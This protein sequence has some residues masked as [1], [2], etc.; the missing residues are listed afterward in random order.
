MRKICLLAGASSVH[1][2]R[3]AN[4]FV[5]RGYEVDLITIHK[6]LPGYDP[7]VKLHFLP[8]PTPIGYFLNVPFV[9][10]LLRRIQPDVLNTHY[11]SGYG[12]LGRL[13]GFH[14]NVLSVWGSDVYE[15]PDT[16]GFH[17]SLLLK[18]LRAADHLCS[19]SLVMARRVR[20]LWP[21]AP[22]L[23]VTPFGIDCAHFSPGGSPRLSDEIVVG[24]VK[25]LAP[26]Y[27]I[28]T[29]VRAFAT[30][31]ESLVSSGNR[32][33]ADRMRLRITGD[34]PQKAEIEA[35][36]DSCGIRAVTTMVGKIPHASVPDEL[37]KLDVYCA[38]SERESES[39]GVAIVEA[40]AC[41]LPVI[42]SRIGGL[43]EVTR[44]GETGLHVEKGHVGQ[45]AAAIARLVSDK[46]LREA[47]G[48]A[49]RALVLREFEWGENI[50]RLLAVLGAYSR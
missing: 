22:R 42:V 41:E 27:G 50:D 45:A 19:T 23:E 24:T 7:R 33:I 5:E 36:I 46:D 25:T 3:W 47:M 30:A 21:Q 40:S 17:K 49:G 9:R 28:T 4:A 44:D 13:A 11:A 31:R 1:T 35:L 38:F 10:R 8:F 2:M 39:F 20:E 37:R 16:S 43:T 26:K 32:A 14:P 6:P 15:F 48:K 34:G 18:N 29:L 12:T